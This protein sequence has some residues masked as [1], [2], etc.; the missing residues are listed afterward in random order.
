MS[1]FLLQRAPATAAA[2]ETSMQFT[3]DIVIDNAES[4]A[5]DD[6]ASENA[7][8]LTLQDALPEVPLSDISELSMRETSSRLPSGL[9][10]V[11]SFSVQYAVDAVL[12][13]LGY[14]AWQ[15]EDVYSE[16]VAAVEASVSSGQFSDDL[17]ENADSTGAAPLA[18]A[19]VSTSQE[20][21]FSNYTLSSVGTAQEGSTHSV[22]VGTRIGYMV[23]IF[24]MVCMSFGLSFMEERLF[25]GNIPRECSKER[26]RQYREVATITK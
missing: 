1:V 10:S 12:E 11:S 8:R 24:S 20:V 6:S 2:T 17:S 14:S 5:A 19:T 21:V 25:W 9:S 26:K 18:G 7:L 3:V 16:W 22:T 4:S 23:F 15:C 13:D